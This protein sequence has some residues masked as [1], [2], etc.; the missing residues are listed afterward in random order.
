[1]PGEDLH[2]SDQMRSQAHSEAL[3]AASCSAEFIALRRP[4]TD[5]DRERPWRRSQLWFASCRFQDPKLYNKSRK[6]VQIV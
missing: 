6:S 1:M 3:R 5:Y 4:I 2:L